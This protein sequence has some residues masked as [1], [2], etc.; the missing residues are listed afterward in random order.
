VLT[1]VVHS[2]DSYVVQVTLQHPNKTEIVP[3]LD[4]NATIPGRY[5]RATVMFGA[6]NSTD[7]YWQ[8]YAVGPLPVTNSSNLTPLTYPFNNQRPGQTRVHP[9]F[10]SSDGVLFLTKLSTDIEDITKELW[11][12]VC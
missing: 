12:S 10:S 5:A 4:G 1:Q 7:S 2:Q 6:T 3:Y 8:E 11:N 9:I